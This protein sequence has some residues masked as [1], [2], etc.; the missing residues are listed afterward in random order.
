LQ[1]GA[2]IY[3]IEMSKLKQYLLKVIDWST[4]WFG[5]LFLGLGFVFDKP[6]LRYVAIGFYLTIVLEPVTD[7]LRK[8][9]KI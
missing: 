5:N 3:L 2:S 8:K 7:Y 9:Y 6:P 4:F 1:P